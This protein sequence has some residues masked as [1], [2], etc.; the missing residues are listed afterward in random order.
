MNARGNR[1]FLVGIM[2]ICCL[3]I[4]PLAEKRA[5]AVANIILIGNI[6]PNAYI[7]DEKLYIS[8]EGETGAQL[9]LG[10]T[11]TP[12]LVLPESLGFL[13]ND[14]SKISLTYTIPGLLGSVTR[15]LR[16]NELDYDQ[17]NSIVSAKISA[18]ISAGLGS[19]MSFTYIFDLEGIG[20]V[21][22]PGE[23]PLYIAV[24]DSLIEL[25]VLTSTD[26]KTTLVV[27]GDGA[28]EKTD[29]TVTVLPS[30]SP[31]PEVVDP[32]NPEQPYEP[33][34]PSTGD[35]GALTLDYVSPLHFGTHPV[36]N[37]AST[38]FADTLQPFIQVTDRR[39]TGKGWTLTAQ[40]SRFSSETRET[41]PGATLY[42]ANGSVISARP[43]NPPE[44]YSNIRLVSGGESVPVLQAS[45]GSGLGTWTTRW[46]PINDG[47]LNDNVILEIPGG[48]ATMG[49]H[50]AEVT[51]TLVD[52][53]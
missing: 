2:I 45:P 16:E 22:T 41:L 5:E 6:K 13:L 46:F 49:T 53:P 51:W 33:G 50:T 4:S 34:D 14:R 9:G 39:G 43:G 8:L 15:T 10:V 35:T 28:E 7:N 44:V 24:G 19:K 25:N 38:Y 37:T 1:K 17:D 32:N 40:V 48:A 20:E 52:A 23:Y 27:E 29:V 11:Y 30:D 3:V 12:Q 31:A 42:L 21:I 47:D 36:E 26:F 18:L